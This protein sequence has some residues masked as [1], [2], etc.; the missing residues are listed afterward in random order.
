MT[1]L[2]D[3]LLEEKRPVA[4]YPIMGYWLD[5]GHQDDYR[6]AQKDV[7]EKDLS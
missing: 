5:V 1:D 2:I 7:V 3:R 4:T 6:K